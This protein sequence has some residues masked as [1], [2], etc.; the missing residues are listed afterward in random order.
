MALS[1]FGL[2]A[3]FFSD[4]CPA[5]AAGIEPVLGVGDDCALLA[6]SPGHQLA[7]S[8]DTLVNGVHFPPDAPAAQL[9]WRALAVSIS[10]LAAMGASPLGFTL[11]LTLPAAD[12]DWL[13]EFSRGLRAAAEHYA[14]PLIGGDTTRGPLSLSLQVHG[15]LPA[16]QALCRRGARVGDR[17]YVSGSLGDSALAL[18]CLIAPTDIPT[19]ALSAPQQTFLLQRYYRPEARLAL[20]EALRAVA[21][22]AIDISDGLLAD[23]GHIAKA[24]A[25]AIC[26]DSEYL[27][28]SP[29][30]TA[31]CERRRALMM[32]LSGG[33][34][35]ELAFCVAP[36]RVPAVAA[37]AETLGLPLSCI[38]EVLAGEGVSCR[39]GP[40]NLLPGAS[41]YQHF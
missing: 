27:P 19:V 26:V 34:D 33:D 35:Y 30:M 12:G 21:S 38:G 16:G 24:S 31:V 5:A 40:D 29:V 9:A 25:V 14:I 4:I 3:Q 28:L 7:V 6:L 23:L 36:E 8:V 10:D 41:G 11:A 1:E 37:L 2:I 15:Q 18:R 17:V 22:A 39:S 13:R 20:G 32:A